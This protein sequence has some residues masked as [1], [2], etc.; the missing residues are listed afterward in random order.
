MCYGF[1]DQSDV[2]FRDENQVAK[3]HALETKSGIKTRYRQDY[4][5]IMMSFSIDP[6]E[7]VLNQFSRFCVLAVGN[8]EGEELSA[9]VPSLYASARS[10][11]P[12]TPAILAMAWLKA[13]P[14]ATVNQRMGAARRKYGEAVVKLREALQDPHTAKADDALFTVL[15]MLMIE[16]SEPFRMLCISLVLVMSLLTSRLQNMTATSS[17]MPNPIKHISGAVMLVNLRGLQNFA[18]DAARA[19]LFFVKVTLV[20]PS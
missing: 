3:K 11:S 20:C 5:P 17:S 6:D 9:I 16:V 10:A 19:M 8:R 14:F 13:A 12:C 18:S 7:A 15:F 4:S 1:R 2:I